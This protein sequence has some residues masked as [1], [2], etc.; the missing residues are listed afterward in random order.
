MEVDGLV[1][2]DLAELVAAIQGEELVALASELLRIPSVNPKDAADCVRMGIE[3]GE[4]RLVEA[5][6]VRLRGAGI[7]VQTE[8]IAPGRPNLV[9][10]LRGPEPGPLLAFNAHTDTVGAFAM[11][12]RAFRPEVRRGALYGRGAVDMKGALACFVLA[13]EILARH[14]YPHSGEVVLTAVIGEE[15]P[16]SGSEHLARQGFHPEGII[17]GEASGCRIFTGQ[18]GGQFVRLTTLGKSGH[19]SMPDSGVN[20]IDEMMQLLAAAPNMEIITHLQG[21]YAAP[22]WSVGTIRGGVRTNVIPDDCVATIDVRIPPGIQPV[23]VLSSMERLAGELGISAHVEAEETGYPAYLTDPDSR[24]VRLARKASRMLVG[25]DDTDLAPYWSDLAYFAQA[26]VPG[27]VIGPGS[28]LQAHSDEEYV[29]V[30]QLIRA[31]QLY[32][33]IAAL[34]CGGGAE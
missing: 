4:G 28:I 23:D 21:Q 11:G 14:A 7:D 33:L 5:L 30:S 13:L 24:L 12:E 17:V 3:P 26:G 10:R 6:A 27:V 25:H 15:G 34:F 8:E 1:Q 32:V 20:A 9:A 19:G 2:P 16:P 29:D 31:T 22:T 18:R